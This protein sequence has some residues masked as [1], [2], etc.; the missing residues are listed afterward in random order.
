MSRLCVSGACRPDRC[1]L[2]LFA[3][4]AETSGGVWIHQ[5]SRRHSQAPFKKVKGAIQL[6]LFH[7]TKPYFFVAVRTPDFVVDC[8]VDAVC[9][10]SATCACTTSRS[11]S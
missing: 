10:R 2:T 7:P 8:T 11:R 6:V 3:A 9:R 1:L 4:G 5:L